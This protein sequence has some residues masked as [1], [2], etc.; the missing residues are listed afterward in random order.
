LSARDYEFLPIFPTDRSVDA[1][2]LACLPEYYRALR[3][4]TESRTN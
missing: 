1:D 2:A 4:F 3:I